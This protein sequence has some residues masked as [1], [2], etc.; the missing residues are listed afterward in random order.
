MTAHRSDS[1]V[2]R[3]PDDAGDGVLA[4]PDLAGD[5][6]VATA[7]RGEGE[8]LG[9]KGGPTV[10]APGRRPSTLPRAPRA[11]ARPERTRS[12]VSSRSNSAMPA[13]RVA[14]IRPCGVAR[15][16]VMPLSAT[17]DTR[18]ASSS[19][20]R[21]QEVGG[22]AAPARQLG[23]EHGV[24]LAGLGERQDAGPLASVAPRA[25]GGLLEDAHDL[26]ASTPGEGSEVALLS[27]AG[28]V[29]CR[30]PAVERGARRLSQLN[31]P[32]PAASKP[33]FALAPGP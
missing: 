11:A 5:Q 22:A 31:P 8:D 30:D 10:A 33:L 13:S 24:D 17:S 32:R 12:A 2:S 27:L 14:I 6:A 7:L 18:R 20:S 26:V 1:G 3:P 23:D 25:R 28:L 29:P 16:K 15:S 4:Q 9:R 21:R 19:R